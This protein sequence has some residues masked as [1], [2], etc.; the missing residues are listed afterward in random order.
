MQ[1]S[2]GYGAAPA[3]QSVQSC[4]VFDPTHGTVLHIHERVT[5]EGGEAVSDYDVEQRA[6]SLA[7]EIRELDS[8]TLRA[9]HVDPEQLEHL[10]SRRQRYAVDLDTST[11]VELRALPPLP[12]ESSASSL[13]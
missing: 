2:Q 1:R 3:E 9:I 6:L 7:A 13:G 12:F 11:L 4:V 10:V 5:L 8:S